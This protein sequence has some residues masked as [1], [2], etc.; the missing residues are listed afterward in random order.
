MG[1]PIFRLL[2]VMSIV[3]GDMFCLQQSELLGLIGI[4]GLED[5]VRIHGGL[6]LQ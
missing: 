3:R 5:D 4:K 6:G 2:P 1:K